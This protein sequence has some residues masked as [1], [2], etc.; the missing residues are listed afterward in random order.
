MKN[1]AFFTRFLMPP[2][3]GGLQNEVRGSPG[4]TQ[5]D[6]GGAP[7]GP[8][9]SPSSLGSPRASFLESPGPPGLIF[10]VLFEV[11]FAIILDI[12]FDKN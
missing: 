9:A 10:G 7:G 12:L 4:S 2:G 5:N 3:P 11:I 8:G 6:A 1:H